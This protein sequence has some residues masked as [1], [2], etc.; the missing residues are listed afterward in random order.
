MRWIL[1]IS[2]LLLLAG[3]GPG[4]KFTGNQRLTH[5]EMLQRATHVFM[6]VVEKQEFEN[7]PL[8]YIPG[9]SSRYWRILR[10][11][12]RVEMVLRGNEPM[13]KG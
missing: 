3:C 9:G 12:V 10:R 6:G 11:T 8:L 5:N 7:W 2:V 4:L 13:E 1:P